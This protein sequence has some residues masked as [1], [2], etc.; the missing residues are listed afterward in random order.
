MTND[1][2]ARPA[3]RL[4]WTKEDD[5][6]EVEVGGARLLAHPENGVALIDGTPHNVPDG[7]PAAL[8]AAESIARRV[9]AERE[10][11][12][13]AGL[14]ALNGMGPW[15]RD[16]KVTL[17]DDVEGE[18]PRRV[19]AIG[20]LVRNGFRLAGSGDWYGFDGKK[21]HGHG[22]AFVRP[23]RDGDE[24]A[25]LEETVRLRLVS[26]RAA[27]VAQLKRDRREAEQRCAGAPWQTRADLAKHE[28]AVRDLRKVLADHE[29]RK[30]AAAARVAEID[31][32][33]AALT[34]GAT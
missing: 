25:I 19:A 28:S 20:R 27:R 3:P 2:E 21:T 7:V 29:A 30:A 5:R 18:R 14:A 15:Q 34:G 26:E 6:Y 23:Y 22:T 10:A 1:N 17:C 11:N 31:A 9:F 16:A 24:D 32:E 8:L 12:A 4:A 33:I 13:A